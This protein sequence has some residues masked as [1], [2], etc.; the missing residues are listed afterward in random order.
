MTEGAAFRRTARCPGAEPGLS[1]VAE[2]EDDAQD[3][4]HGRARRGA[5]PPC[6]SSPACGESRSTRVITGAAGGAVAGEVIADEPLAG[7]VIGGVAGALR[8]EGRTVP[9][10]PGGTRRTRTAAAAPRPFL[11]CPTRAENER[12]G[13]MD[14]GSMAARAAALVALAMLAA[15]DPGAPGTVGADPMTRGQRHGRG[16]DR[17]RRSDGARRDRRRDRH[18][19]PGRVSGGGRPVRPGERCSRRS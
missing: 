17:G 19:D 4:A 18:A 9:D 5:A 10:A 8:P 13:K 6:C 15:C 16:R 12:R 14:D 1:R 11:A 7:A 2:E 3:H